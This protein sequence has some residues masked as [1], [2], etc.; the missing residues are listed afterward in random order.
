M[1]QLAGPHDDRL[2]IDGAETLI[3]EF[4][5]PLVVGRVMGAVD[6]ARSRVL[7]GYR[8]LNLD[9]PPSDEFVSL[10]IGLARQ[11]LAAV[12]H[13]PLDRKGRPLRIA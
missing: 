7:D 1:T 5:P 8:V 2:L 4:C 3:A 9:A 6:R 12:G 10:V 13:G 11:E